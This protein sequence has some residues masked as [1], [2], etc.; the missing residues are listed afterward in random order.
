MAIYRHH[1]NLILLGAN[2]Y[3]GLICFLRQTVRIIEHFLLPLPQLS[4]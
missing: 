3:T 2:G 1:R 4:T